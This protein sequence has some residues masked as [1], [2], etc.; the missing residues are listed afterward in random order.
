MRKSSTDEHKKKQQDGAQCSLCDH[1]LLFALALSWLVYRFKSAF[2]C[3]RP[4][5]GFSL[6]VFLVMTNTRGPV[7][8]SI[9]KPQWQFMPLNETHMHWN[10]FSS[11]AMQDHK[12]ELLT[13]QVAL[14]VALVAG[15]PL[16]TSRKTQLAMTE[17]HKHFLC[18]P[19]IHSVSRTK[20]KPTLKVHFSSRCVHRGWLH[21][22]PPLCVMWFQQQTVVKR[23]FGTETAF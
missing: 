5:L 1:L 7:N 9:Q 19:L 4:I 2:H 12:R 6:P 18:K 8:L 14:Q 15:K 16:L 17:L 3:E 11:I 13:I 21:V 20:C 22:C 10:F 23:V